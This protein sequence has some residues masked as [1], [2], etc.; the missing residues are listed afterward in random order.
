MQLARQPL[1]LA[2]KQLPLQLPL[3][4]GVVNQMSD[5]FIAIFFVSILIGLKKPIYGGLAGL[6]LGLIFCFFTI[7]FYHHQ[8]IAIPVASYLVG[9]ILPL[10]VRWFFS[11]YR[12]GRGKTNPGVTYIGGFG[13]GRAGQYFEKWSEGIIPSQNEETEWIHDKQSKRERII[14]IIIRYVS[15]PI[16]L[17]IAM[18]AAELLM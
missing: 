13:V 16:I 18:I 1:L 7:N 14:G 9:L 5:L 11:G 15:A 6:F 4:L 10:S 8:W 17:L 12:G 2:Q 3:N